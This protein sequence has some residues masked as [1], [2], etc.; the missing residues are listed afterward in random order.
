M[1]NLRCKTLAAGL[2]IAVSAFGGSITYDKQANVVWVCDFLEDAPATAD[3]LLAADRQHGW[4]IVRYDTATDVYSLDASLYIGDDK[5]LGA[6]FQIGRPGH[7]RETLIVRGD[8]WIRPPKES[9]TRTDG[10]PAIVN[11]LTLGN[12][13]DPSIH[14]TLKIACKTRGQ[15]GVHVGIREKGLWIR[16]GDLYVYNST[17]TAATPDRQHA[18]KSRGW[19]GS[20]I[21]LVN[22]TLSWIDGNMTYGVDKDNSVIEGTTFAHGGIALRNGAQFARGC[23]FRDLQ[24]AVA[25]GGCLDATLVNCVFE[26]NERNWTLGNSYGRGIRMIDC[27]VDPQSKPI[28][29]RKNKV[30]PK[31]AAMRHIPIYPTYSEWASLAVKVTDGRAA[32]IFA[33]AVN[34]ECARYPDAVQNPLALTDAKG[35]TPARVEDAILI[36]TKRLQPTDTPG[37]VRSFLFSYRVTVSAAGFKEKAVPLAGMGKIPRPL[38]VVLE[39]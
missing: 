34:V 23:T 35:L 2:M 11:R 30:D 3:D 25:E 21:R 4:G 14:A 9:P 16:R 33:A 6:F 15:F 10:R 39:K 24:T 32:P 20:S 27:K 18:L 31:R 22:A 19:Y 17:I 7:P 28:Q 26:H 36:T 38:V 29:L 8:V 5:N 13:A 1:K 12:P 37:R